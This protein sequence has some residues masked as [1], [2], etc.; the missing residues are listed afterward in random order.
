MKL[1]LLILLV[2]AVSAGL[3]YA[4]L[5]AMGWPPYL[6]EMIAAARSKHAGGGHGAG[7]RRCCIGPAVRRPS[8]RARFRE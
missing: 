5:R 4:V 1:I 3:G 6:K 7:S 2:V 8:F